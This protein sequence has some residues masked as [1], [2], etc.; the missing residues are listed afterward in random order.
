MMLCICACKNIRYKLHVFWLFIKIY[1]YMKVT[2]YFPPPPGCMKNLHLLMCGNSSDPYESQVK[3]RGLNSGPVVKKQLQ[4]CFFFFNHSFAN[5]F[6]IIKIFPGVCL[7]WALQKKHIGGE[8]LS[9][10]QKKTKNQT[11]KTPP[12]H[13][14]P[15]ILPHHPRATPFPSMPPKP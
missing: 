10:P 1:T 2:K 3:E 7:S 8:T 4:K 6:V 13:L 5:T 9:Q 11:Q 12:N 14:P 15:N